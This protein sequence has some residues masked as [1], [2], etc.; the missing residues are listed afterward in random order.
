MAKQG[1][2]DQLGGYCTAVHRD[3]GLGRTRTGIVDSP[4]EQL[5]AC[6]GFTIDQHGHQLVRQHFG[7]LLEQQHGFI[8]RDDVVEGRV[9]RSSLYDHVVQTAGTDL[10]SGRHILSSDLKGYVDLLNALF[11]RRLVIG[12]GVARLA[13]QNPYRLHRRR[14]RTEQNGQWLTAAL[15]PAQMTLCSLINLGKVDR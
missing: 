13:Q 9:Y 15:Q 2:V 7:L 1:R 12:G 4:G 5:L 11:Q 6:T 14:T 8:A 3:K 10:C